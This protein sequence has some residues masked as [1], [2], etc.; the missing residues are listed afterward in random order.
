[1]LKIDEMAAQNVSIFD[2]F[3][4]FWAKWPKRVTYLYSESHG[5]AYPA[6]P[7]YQEPKSSIGFE[8]CWKLTK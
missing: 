4:L 2:V 1:M 5:T 8:K 6:R 7:S 3:W